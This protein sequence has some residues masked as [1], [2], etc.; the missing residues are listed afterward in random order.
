MLKYIINFI[1]DVFKILVGWPSPS[2]KVV[3]TCNYVIVNNSK[4]GGTIMSTTVKS[5]TKSIK[6]SFGAPVDA[7]G[8]AAQVEDGSVSLSSDNTDIAT[9]EPDPD[10]AYG[11]IATLTGK[12]GVAK[13]NISADADLGEGV[14]SITGFTALEVQAGEAVGF[15]EATFG[16][17]VLEETN[18]NGGAEGGGDNQPVTE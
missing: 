8:N 7:K 18:T 6:F 3:W 1:I 4:I 10:N 13:L 14:K 16:E 15:G 12:A 11:G 17:P 2:P 5:N 9:V